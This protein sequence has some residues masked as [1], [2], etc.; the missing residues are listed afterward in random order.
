LGVSPSFSR[1]AVSNDNP[2]SKS[3]FKPLKYRSTYPRQA[4]ENL[5]EAR[6]WVGEFAQ[7]Y[8]EEHRHS[9]INFVTPAERH[10]GLDTALLAKRTIVYETAKSRHPE[11]WSRATR[12]WQPILEVH[13]NPDQKSTE[14]GEKTKG[15]IEPKMAA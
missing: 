3:L 12:N 6:K 10:A 15:E 1:P 9:A 4:F 8:N 5:L 7:W 14:K 2:Y 11:R 13:L